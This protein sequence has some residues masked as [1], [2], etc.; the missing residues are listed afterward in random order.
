[1]NKTA[2]AKTTSPST[3]VRATSLWI[4]LL[5][6]WL[7]WMFDGME[8]GLYSVLAAPAL[9]DLLGVQDP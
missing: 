4:I 1:M 7:G 5:V 2:E 9:K 8:M 3:P 6:A